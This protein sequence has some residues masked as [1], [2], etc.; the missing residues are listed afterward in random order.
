[1]A[2]RDHRIKIINDVLNGIKVIQASFVCGPRTW[3][4]E[5]GQLIHFCK[6]NKGNLC[7]LELTRTHV[8][9]R[10]CVR[11]CVCVCVCVGGWVGG[12]VQV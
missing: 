4:G 7:V 10:A 6:R 5:A 3:R 11:A 9:V 8:C 12:W 1:M 2:E